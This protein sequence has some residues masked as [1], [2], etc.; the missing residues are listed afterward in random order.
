MQENLLRVFVVAVGLLMC[1]RDDPVDEE[2]DDISV[3]MQE[4]EERL[5]REEKLDQEVPPVSEK[6]LRHTDSK[7]LQH[8]ILYEYKKSH[9]HVTQ[10]D[11]V[12]DLGTTV[13]KQDMEK[14]RTGQKIKERFRSKADARVPQKYD[15]EPETDTKTAPNTH[16]LKETDVHTDTFLRDLSRPQGHGEELEEDTFNSKQDTPFSHVHT[17][18]KENESG[19]HAVADWERDYL[20]YILNTF[21]VISMIRFCRKY[22]KR[23]SLINQEKT[24]APPVACHVDEVLIPDIGTL[25]EF[26]VKCVQASSEKKWREDEFLEGFASDLLETMQETCIQN[27]SLVVKDFHIRNSCDII[28]PLTPLEPY[29]FQCELW[30][31]HSS[32]SVSDM[33]ACG[34][35]KLVENKKIQNGC[36]CQSSGADDVVCL[37]HYENENV[38]TTI[39]DACDGFL[40]FKDTPFL[41]K[42]QVSRWFQGTIK[43]AWAQI[44]HK[45]EFELI[46]RNIDAPGM[47]VIRF[48]SGK[49]ITFCMNPVVTFNSDAHFFITPWSLNDLDTLW[50]LSVTAY[51]DHLLEHLSVQLPEKSCHIQTLEI[52]CFL[53]KRQKALTGSSALKDFHFKTALLH[54]LLTKDP[55]Q[56]KVNYVALRLRDLLAFIERSLKTKCLNH[57]LFGNPVTKF[58]E[59]PAEFIKAKPVNLFY[60]LVAHDCMYRNAVMH[61]QEMLR[62]THMLIH[63]YV[64]KSSA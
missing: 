60:P 40:C 13:T 41:S 42:S 7:G 35:I 4:H 27:G 23:N 12:S 1:P 58:I 18:T 8:D 28:V 47:L 43:Q 22:L 51:E 31:D 14:D 15:G 5:R 32:D 33:Q 54:L 55:S 62:N 44:S 17:K 25:Q 50:A 11:E 34:R 38:K 29:S 2:W 52:A 24:I 36:D 57:V 21:S 49:R 39:T 3:G 6:L 10:K 16:E 45:Y 48:K 46:I 53:H 64:T 63:D 37:L 61:F 59:L 20:W 26:Y 56:W 19:E 30:K 9:Q